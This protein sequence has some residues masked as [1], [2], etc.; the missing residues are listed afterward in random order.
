[1][2]NKKI[3]TQYTIYYILYTILFL[4]AFLE[5]TVWDLGPNIE[6]VTAAMILASFYL[7]R[8]SAFWLTFAIIALSDRIIGNSKIFLFTWSG[9]LL[10]ALFISPIL[11]KLA[12]YYQ[13]LTT[14]KIFTGLP[15]VFVGLSANIFFYLWTNLGVWV[16]DSWGMYTKDL[17]GLIKCYIYG[18]P[19]LKNQIISSLIFIPMGYFV[20]EIAFYFY[21]KYFPASRLARQRLI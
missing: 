17:P 4:A 5:R 9:F 2:L 6:L 19:F 10:P 18:L 12:T 16:L 11:K 3:Q 15:L 7:G 20:I 1:M 8:K 14:K 13:L 21:K